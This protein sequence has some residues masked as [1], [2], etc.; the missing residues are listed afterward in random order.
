MS[1]SLRNFEGKPFVIF[2]HAHIGLKRNY[3]ACKSH[4]R[5][6]EICYWEIIYFH[7]VAF[8][9]H[10]AFLEKFLHFMDKLDW[11]SAIEV[12][13]PFKVLNFIRNLFFFHYFLLY[14]GLKYCS[15]ILYI[16]ESS[17]SGTLVSIL[18]I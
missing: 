8:C 7:A 9:L 1:P 3:V 2:M 4:C 5:C 17:L 6:L 15:N 10:L 18:N 16:F 13:L 11:W 12:P 14:I